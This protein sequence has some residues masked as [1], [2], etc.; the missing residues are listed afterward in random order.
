MTAS[1]AVMLAAGDR[2]GF[3][4]VVD[5]DFGIPTSIWRRGFAIYRAGRG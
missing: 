5:L 2:A 1:A 4:F 3:G